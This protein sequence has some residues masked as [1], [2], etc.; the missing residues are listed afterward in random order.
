MSKPAPDLTSAIDTIH[1]AMPDASEE[2]IARELRAKFP[3][4]LSADRDALIDAGLD[5]MINEAKGW[6]SQVIAIQTEEGQWQIE[7]ETLG[8]LAIHDCVGNREEPG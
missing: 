2:E 7:A 3:E 1:Q 8:L 4:V 6:M 5:S